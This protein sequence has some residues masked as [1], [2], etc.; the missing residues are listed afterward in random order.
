M[1]VDFS[2]LQKSGPDIRGPIAGGWCRCRDLGRP[3]DPDLV[4]FQAM[5]YF[6]R[7][8]PSPGRSPGQSPDGN[9]TLKID[10]FGPAP[11]RFPMLRN[12]ASG[13]EI[14]LPGRTIGIAQNQKNPAQ[15]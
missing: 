2:G 1:G 7:G 5:V 9:F 8:P 4:V 13:P 11:A 6:V 10:S 14:G 3:L 12:N 15:T